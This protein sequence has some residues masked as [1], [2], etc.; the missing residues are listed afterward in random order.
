MKTSPLYTDCGVFVQDT[1]LPFDPH[2]PQGEG[3]TAELNYMKRH[4]ELYET[5][6]VDRNYVPRPGDVVGKP[7]P[8]NPR[9]GQSRQGHI[10]IILPGGGTGEASL[11]HFHG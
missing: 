10:G 11:L 4:P 6:K 1:M 5:G 7:K 9:P 8:K 3:A 2:Y